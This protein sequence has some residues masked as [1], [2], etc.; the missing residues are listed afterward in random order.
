M[1]STLTIR[2]PKEQRAALKRRAAAQ[3]KTEFDRVR[4]LIEKETGRAFYFENVRHLAGT[5]AVV[6]ANPRRDAGEWRKHLREVN[7]RK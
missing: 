6:R 5:V 1:I 2:L 3:C 7:W 4:E